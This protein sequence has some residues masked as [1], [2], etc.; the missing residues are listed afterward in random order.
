MVSKLGYSKGAHQRAKSEF[1]V[2]LQVLDFENIPDFYGF[3]GNPYR[4][5][6]GALISAPNGWVVNAK[7]PHELYEQ[8]LCFIHPFEYTFE[9]AMKNK[10]FMYF[11][12]VM[13]IEFVAII[14]S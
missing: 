1:E 9:K 10:Q 2:Q 7:I 8:M 13:E 11:Q 4:G 5:H 12:I 6:L 3:W 14:C